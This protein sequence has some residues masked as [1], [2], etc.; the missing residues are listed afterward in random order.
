L[1]QAAVKKPTEMTVSATL[2]GII[3]WPP[4]LPVAKTKLHRATGGT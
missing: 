1:C 2:V 3:A 4:F